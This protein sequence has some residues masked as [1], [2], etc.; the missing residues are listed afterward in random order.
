MKLADLTVIAACLYFFGFGVAYLFRPTMADILGLQ[1]VNPAGKTEI[2]C[3]Y[4]GV[5][6]ALSA[7]FAYL[8]AQHHAVLALTGVLFLATAVLVTRLIGTTVD[9]GWSERYTRL[10]LPIETAFVVVLVVIRLFT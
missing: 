6:W 7:F 8:L 2:R 3:Y 4:G 1:W 10:A 5:S 9:H